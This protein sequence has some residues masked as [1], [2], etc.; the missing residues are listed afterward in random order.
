MPPKKTSMNITGEQLAD[1]TETLLHEAP[2]SGSHDSEMTVQEQILTLQQQ[3]LQQSQ[4]FT[5]AMRLQQEQMAKMCEQMAALATAQSANQSPQPEIP[6]SND[7]GDPN[8]QVDQSMPE[9][10][11][12]P[13]APSSQEPTS[14]SYM[15]DIV[16]LIKTIKNTQLPDQKYRQIQKANLM[17]KLNRQPFQLLHDHLRFRTFLQQFIFEFN[18]GDVDFT[19][20]PALFRAALDTKSVLYL[21]RINANFDDLEQ[22]VLA[23]AKRCQPQFSDLLELQHRFQAEMPAGKS[24][25]DYYNH[26]WEYHLNT[27]SA[28]SSMDVLRHFMNSCPQQLLSLLHNQL[29]ACNGCLE[30]ERIL[31]IIR[32]V[33][34]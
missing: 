7:L 27:P 21:R 2:A 30:Q 31:R 13:P 3:L 6:S 20:A 9:A 14:T 28:V 8:Q 29:L 22:L 11:H 25:E 33:P 12:S 10:P 17:Q 24:P 15:V 1:A 34:Q 26:L 4:Q 23:M 16:Q 5:S 19:D 32:T 18:T